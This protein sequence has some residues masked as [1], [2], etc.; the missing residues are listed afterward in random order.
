MIVVC[1]VLSGCTAAST[2][3]HKATVDVDAHK[4][5]VD[6][7]WTFAPGPNSG[8]FPV[9]YSDELGILLVSDDLAAVKPGDSRPPQ[10]YALD[11]DTGRAIWTLDTGSQSAEAFFATPG[12]V[13]AVMRPSAATLLPADYLQVRALSSADGHLLWST[14]LG[15]GAQVL[16]LSG[17]SLVTLDAGGTTA[18][19]AATGSVSWT[20]GVPSG[21]DDL[22]AAADDDLIE[23][24]QQCSGVLTL[25]GVDPATGEPLWATVL[26]STFPKQHV[27]VTVALYGGDGVVTIDPGGETLFSRTGS[28]LVRF[29]ADEGGLWELDGS[30]NPARV[31]QDQAAVSL[32]EF[33]PVTG[34]RL[35]QSSVPDPLSPPSQEPGTPYADSFGTDTYL[36]ASLPAPLIPAG[37]VVFDLA[38]SRSTLLILPVADSSVAGLVA[39]PRDVY[40]TEISAGTESVVAYSR[41]GLDGTG[42]PSPPA[43]ENWPQACAL[44]PAR[45][46]SSLTGHSYT[47]YGQPVRAD[48]LPAGS[49]CLYS[50]TAP[51]QPGLEV[52]VA[53]DGTS[54]AATADLAVQASSFMTPVANLGDQAYELVHDDPYTPELTCDVVLR[55]GT[56]LVL[57]KSSNSITLASTVAPAIAADLASIEGG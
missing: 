8:L 27:F 54:D 7:E 47:S 29:P 21:C 6:A 52:D 22:A 26:S 15:D 32:Q 38:D 9:Y 30:G 42:T 51:G 49:N 4:A 34:A 2:G 3:A 10:I 56:V 33:D 50:T 41:A 23:V 55:V 24:A 11:P 5:T 25:I 1:A 18:I 35:R 19:S 13:L 36:L 37:L 45:R 48:G 53:W 39:G 31:G 57:V 46:L 16:G 28:P 20:D 12:T 40:V 14:G 44:L 17:D 43:A